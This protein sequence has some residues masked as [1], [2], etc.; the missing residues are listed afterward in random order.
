MTHVAIR[1]SE[2]DAT[3]DFY[4]RYA[5]LH[6]VHERND[7]GIR[8]AWLSHAAED[9]DFVIV[10]LQMPH[11]PASDPSPTDH[12]G[13]DVASRDEV[14]RIAKLASEQGCLRYGPAE[15]GAIV[16]YFCMLRDPSG[17]VCEFSHGQPINPRAIQR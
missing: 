1:T 5:G 16:G 3:L 2:F 17:N 9:P 8:V 10:L 15:G 14:D 13:F 7:A 11:A 6:I 4:R 12:F